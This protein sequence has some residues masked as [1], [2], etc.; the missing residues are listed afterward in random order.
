MWHI[1]NTPEQQGITLESYWDLGGREV[2]LASAPS[3][4]QKTA[5]E[6]Q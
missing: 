4:P 6:S 3:T 5:V 2:E 1:P